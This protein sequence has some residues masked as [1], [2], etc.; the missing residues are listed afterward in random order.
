MHTWN[1]GKHTCHPRGAYN[2][3]EVLSCV[4]WAGGVRNLHVARVL[5]ILFDCHDALSELTASPIIASSAS[6]RRSQLGASRSA[7]C[8]CPHV[9]TCNLLTAYYATCESRHSCPT[10]RERMPRRA[11]LL[12]L[13]DCPRVP[14]PSRPAGWTDSALVSVCLAALFEQRDFH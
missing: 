13:P 14:D 2:F 8:Q 6:E 4:G 5:D 10:G 7:S 12:D 1:A 11:E 9:Q 3:H